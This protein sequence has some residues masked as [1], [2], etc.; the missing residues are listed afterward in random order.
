VSN[1]RYALL[2]I[3]ATEVPGRRAWGAGDHRF[4][5]FPLPRG[6]FSRVKDKKAGQ[7]VDTVENAGFTVVETVDNVESAIVALLARC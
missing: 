1:Q 4:Q 6:G 2:G 7:I 3:A 5:P